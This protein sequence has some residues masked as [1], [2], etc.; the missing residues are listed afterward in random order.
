MTA[1][2]PAYLDDPAAC[3][4]L[5]ACAAAGIEARFV[6]GCVRDAVLGRLSP[7]I[8]LAAAAPP[9]RIAAALDD[10]GLRHEPT[11]IDHGTLTVVLNGRGFE[12]TALRRD[13]AT[14]G[15]RATVAFTTHW[16][17]DAARRD[18]TMNA[19]SMNGDGR[20]FDPFG[21]VADAQAGRIRF[22]GVAAERVREDALRILRFFRF[23]ATH[24]APPPDAAALEACAEHASLVD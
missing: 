4:I 3:A 21:G 22:V 5:D 10:A 15:R 13:V 9:K 1:A 14:D 17:E 19:L 11:G 23:T 8:D 20:L 2:R 6:G 7:D 18:F 16:A 12:I 24:G